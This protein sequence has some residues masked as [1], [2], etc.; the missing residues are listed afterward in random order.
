MWVATARLSCCSLIVWKTPEPKILKEKLQ[1][2]REVNPKVWDHQAVFCGVGDWFLLLTFKKYL[3]ENNLHLQ[4]HFVLDNAPACPHN[5]KEDILKGFN[6]IRVLYLLPNITPILQSMDQQGI[7][8]CKNLF[9]KL[10]FC[11]CFEITENTN[12]T[13]HESWEDQMG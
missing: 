4:A 2:T 7:S 1:V 10:L 8:N 5:H 3:Q 6:F 13:L 12:H 11:H 9:T